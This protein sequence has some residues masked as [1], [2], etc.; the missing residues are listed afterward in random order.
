MYCY[1]KGR[2][3]RVKVCSSYNSLG[4]IKIGVPQG[5]VL[6]PM[7]IDVESEVCS[8]AGDNTIFTRGKNLEEA[9][10]KLEGDVCTYLKWFSENRMVANPEK[11]QLMFLGTNMGQKLC[12]KIDDQLIKQCQQ[13]KLLVAA[14]DSRLKL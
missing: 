14:I 9:I 1:L 2:A 13:V 8:F 6:G 5:S 12:L 11:F 7:L 10:I 3:Q 4:N